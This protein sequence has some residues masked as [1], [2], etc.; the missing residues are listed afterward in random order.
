MSIDPKASTQVVKIPPTV[1]DKEKQ[2]QIDN[3]ILADM[4]RRNQGK[5]V[6]DSPTML[7]ENKPSGDHPDAA[8]K[9]ANQQK[10]MRVSIDQV[11]NRNGATSSGSA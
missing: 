8:M 11:N 1:A 4:R 6:A 10:F 7:I 5:G 9:D 2:R 3:E